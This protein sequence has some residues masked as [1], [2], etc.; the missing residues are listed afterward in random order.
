MIDHSSIIRM[1]SRFGRAAARLAFP[2][3]VAG[4]VTGCNDKGL[5]LASVEG[6]VTLDGTP[7]SDAGLVFMPADPS[8]GPPA[9][10]ATD[11]EGKF[12]LMTANQAGAIIGEHRVAISKTEAT[13]IP[14]QRGLPLYRIKDF[15]PAKYGN[16]DTSGL[17]ATVKDDD[18]S[19]RFE[20]SSK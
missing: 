17:T 16:V 1:L 20:L 9:S 18:N 4:A 15:V 11:A 8:R 14:Q 3:A 19:L 12:T 7:V 2:L 13:A 10:G 6:V 5:N